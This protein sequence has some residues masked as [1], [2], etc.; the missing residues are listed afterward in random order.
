M[1]EGLGIADRY[2]GPFLAHIPLALTPLF[3]WLVSTFFCLLASLSSSSLYSNKWA[4]LA[5]NRIASLKLTK[6]SR[7]LVNPIP[8]L[9]LKRIVQWM[10]RVR[11]L[12]PHVLSYWQKFS[13][14]ALGK[15][16]RLLWELEGSR[17]KTCFLSVPTSMGSSLYDIVHWIGAMVRTYVWCPL[18]HFLV[19][20]WSQRA[21]H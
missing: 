8:E 4:N 5:L 2:I 21:I 1:S 17:S 15:T 10:C 11:N 20:S 19:R 13:L 16:Y 14:S 7:P 6:N 3:R 18:S 12:L 9:Q